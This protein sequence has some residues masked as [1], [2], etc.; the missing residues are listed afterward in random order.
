MRLSVI[1]IL[2]LLIQPALAQTDLGNP[3]SDPLPASALLTE[4]PDSLQLNPHSL[5]GLPTGNRNFKGRR[6][7]F[8]AG[9]AAALGLGYIWSQNAWGSSAGKFHWKN[10]WTGDNLA[11][12]DEIS[13]LVICFNI[14]RYLRP[15]YNWLGV[16]PERSALYSS[17]HT[18]TIGTLVEYPIDAHNPLQ[19]LGVSDLIADYAG[20]VLALGQYHFPALDD[21]YLKSSFK[22]APWNSNE[23]ILAGKL[24]EFDNE[25]FWLT[26]K[27]KFKRMDFL[28]AGFGYSTNHHTVKVQR[29]YYI[30]LG[31]TIPEMINIL[32]PKL[33]RIL[34][35]LDLFYLELH[36]R[37]N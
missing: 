11:Q 3:S 20:S 37:L 6:W 36:Q 1:L 32:S 5:S 22:Q 30:G 16:S 25:I 7:I 9:N 17:L 10:D 2:G 4:S 23:N 27:L 34:L 13:H 33:A 35:P 18:A 26:Y 12:N 15:V 24:E 19:G 29:E 8:A 31:T 28:H 21:F 14:S